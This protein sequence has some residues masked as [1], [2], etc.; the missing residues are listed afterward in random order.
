[1]DLHLALVVRKDRALRAGGL[2]DLAEPL[3]LAVRQDGDGEPDDDLG[4]SRPRRQR[5]D[6]GVEVEIVE[7]EG[8]LQRVDDGL[9]DLA[10]RSDFRHGLLLQVALL[11]TLAAGLS[12]REPERK[13]PPENEYPEQTGCYGL[14]AETRRRSG[15][16]LRFGPDDRNGSFSVSVS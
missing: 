10:R 9:R 2:D 1:L 3:E 7:Q 16:I 14:A 15:T 12:V 11:I 13:H 5:A 8:L 4:R 6:L